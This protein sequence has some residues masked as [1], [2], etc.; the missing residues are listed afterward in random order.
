MNKRA[1]TYCMIVVAVA[2]IVMP[3]YDWSVLWELDQAS[4]IG[5]CALVVLAII[6]ESL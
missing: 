3:Q 5:A 4:V 6:S 1:Q 2:L